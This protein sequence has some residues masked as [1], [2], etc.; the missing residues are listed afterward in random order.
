MATIIDVA[1]LAGVSR[2]TVSRVVNQ[3]GYVKTETRLLIQDA[4]RELNYRPNMVAKTLAT[5]RNRTIA[6]VMVNI[7]DPFHNLVSQGLESVA[8]RNHYTTMMCDTHSTSREQ[9]YINMF[10]DFL[11]GG[12][13]LHH[14]AL[15]PEQVRLIQSHGTQCVLMDNEEDIPGVSSVNTNNY[16]GAVMAVEH[17]V[18]RGHRKIGCVHGVLGRP[19]GQDIAYE[20]TFQFNL[21]KQR[22]AGFRDAMASLS[23]PPARLYQSNG[24]I[25]LAIGCSKQIVR[26]ILADP[27]RPTALYCE[28]DIMAIAILNE[29]QEHGIRVPGDIAVIGH[30]GLDICR[31]L[32]PYITTVAQPRY[33]MGREAAKMLIDRIE[34]KCEPRTITLQPAVVAGETT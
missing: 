11:I 15:K 13:I 23:L 4:I 10:R 17:L 18:S 20:D 30:D 19:E 9:D 28:N 27:E 7:S 34:T 31:L 24:R 29:L 5:R 33:E 6:Y 16:G 8:F 25:E 22:T 26:G 2:M 12:V 32:H 14:L 21:W 1:K 3:S